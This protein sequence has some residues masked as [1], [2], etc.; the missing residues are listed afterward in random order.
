MRFQV[1]LMDQAQT[2][3]KVIVRAWTSAPH[4]AFPYL[5]VLLTVVAACGTNATREQRAAEVAAQASNERAQP[6]TSETA[7]AEAHERSAPSSIPS[8]PQQH[9]REGRA[10]GIRYLEVVIGA[11]ADARLPL[12]VFFHGRGDRAH[13]T[14]IRGFAEPARYVFPEA[15]AA[16]GSGFS[17]FSYI[18]GEADTDVVAAAIAGSTENV[19]A[20]LE[21]LVS[22]RPT[23]GKPIVS[24]FS[25]GGHLSFALALLHPESVAFALPVGGDLPEPLWPAHKAAGTQYPAIVALAGRED[26]VIRFAS[27]ERTVNAL[28]E[29]G[30][31]VTLH[32]FDGAGHELRSDMQQLLHDELRAALARTR[33]RTPE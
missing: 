24:G 17:W 19:H 4:I 30:F 5:A 2:L 10:H 6:A 27:T 3:S 21:A 11:D 28:R 14:W 12:V 18:A 26:R 25:Q 1:A 31:D 8:S 16:F 20:M 13:R 7:Q 32:A 33:A 15:K 22:E 29:R 23:R 9:T